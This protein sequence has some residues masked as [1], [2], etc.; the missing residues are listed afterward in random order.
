MPGEAQRTREAATL[1][2]E[3]AR[4]DLSRARL[5]ESPLPRPR[6]GEA[7][8]EVQRFGFSANNVTYALL[9]ERIGYWGLFPARAGWGRIPAWSHLTVLDSAVEG[10]EPGRR[11]YGLAPMASHVVMRPGR[12]GAPG[13]VDSSEHRAGL[14]AVYSAYSWLDADPAHADELGERLLVLR[15]VF[16]L[17]FLLDD[18]L[19]GAH[20]LAGQEVWITSASSKAALGAAQLLGARGAHVV[21]LT[22]GANLEFASGAGIYGE[23]RPYELLPDRPSGS[24]ILIDLAGGRGLRERIESRLGGSR[25]RT[26]LAGA[27][28][29]DAAAAQGESP[30]GRARFV[31]APDRIR[32]RAREL[33]WAELN[34]RYSEAVR[35]FAAASR[36]WLSIERAVGPDEVQAAYLRTLRGEGRPDRA[37]VLALAAAEA[38]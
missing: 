26:L 21:G 20:P 29:Q 8:F 19:A 25:A 11:A 30:D 37:Q 17:S 23:V 2:F 24:T 12:I 16:W 4:E 14:G 33:G 10:I 15:P 27:T 13:F 7:L 35:E 28:H 5:A 6:R 38:A 3:V 22:S 18:M 34:R 32:E 31:F 36:A 9:G 1:A